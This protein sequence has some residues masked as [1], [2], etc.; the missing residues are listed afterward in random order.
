[1]L[2]IAHVTPQVGPI[3][4]GTDRVCAAGRKIPI[5]W[6]SRWP[7]CPS[8]AGCYGEGSSWSGK[9]GCA[10]GIASS[11]AAG[12]RPRA[13]VF[14]PPGCELR[15]GQRLTFLRATMRGRSRWLFVTH[16]IVPAVIVII[17]VFYG[18]PVVERLDQI[19]EGLYYEGDQGEPG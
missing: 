18:G 10:L 3:T 4:S 16:A 6:R 9:F 14:A 7:Q 12:L 11:I 8:S 1:M 17:G 19:G 5:R 13:T 15:C 2:A